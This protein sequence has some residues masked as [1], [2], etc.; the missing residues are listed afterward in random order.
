MVC[1]VRVMLGIRI[2]VDLPEHPIDPNAR[3]VKDHQPGFE[4][5]MV[6]AVGS[7]FPTQA[8]P[9][10]HQVHLITSER[11]FQPGIVSALAWTRGRLIARGQ[12]GA[13]G[14]PG[15]STH[16]PQGERNLGRGGHAGAQKC[17]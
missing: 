2:E 7:R 17:G 3:A 8:A 4:A 16:H 6:A 11:A 5:D 1:A 12:G 9:R 13:G 10:D 15:T 14:V